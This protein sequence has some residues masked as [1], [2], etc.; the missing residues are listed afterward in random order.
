MEIHAF[1]IAFIILLA[2]YYIFVAISNGLLL[3]NKKKLPP[4]PT[5]LPIIG[6]LLTLRGRTHESLV[7]LAQ[8][9]GPLMSL[10]LG[11]VNVVVA[12]SAEM[13]M[14]ILQKHDLEFT[15]RSIPD[16]ATAAQGYDLDLSWLPVGSQ[17]KKLR[18]IYNTHFLT[19]HKLDLQRESRHKVMTS[20]IQ[21]VKGG[22]AVQIRE[23]VLGTVVKLLAN[24]MFSADMEVEEL[25]LAQVLTRRIIP[26]LMKP[27]V[28]DYFPF[29]TPFDLQGIR[30]EIGPSY[31]R[32]HAVIDAIIDMRRKKR[33][34]SG[35]DSRIGDFLDVLIDYTE[36]QGPEGL[37][38]M[39]VKHLIMVSLIYYFKIPNY[40]FNLY[41]FFPHPIFSNVYI[42]L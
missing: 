2:P 28:A 3:F 18:K 33:N 31:N 42:T 35:S 13:A 19:P 17:W 11:F 38:L 40:L 7:K 25:E 16:A 39:D 34:S 6:S 26:L 37:T 32:M 5:G 15:P 1:A 27:N 8:T 22:E 41:F 4:G 12:S 23:L 30:R 10:K 20:M 9:Y 21:R 14:E 36:D 29:L 24:S